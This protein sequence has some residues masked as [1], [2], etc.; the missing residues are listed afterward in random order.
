[1]PALLLQLRE[2]EHHQA[3]L[4]LPRGCQ[5]AHFH[6]RH[7]DHYDDDDD[8]DDNNNNDIFSRVPGVLFPSPACSTLQQR[9]GSNQHRHRPR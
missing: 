1:M 4:H 3:P 5:V 6:D 7:D 9:P 2:R 8:N